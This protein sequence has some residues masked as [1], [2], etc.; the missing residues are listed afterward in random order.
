MAATDPLLL[1]PDAV[2]V[3]VADLPEEVRGRFEHAEGDFALTHPRLRAP[4]RILDAP[5]AE[6]LEQFRT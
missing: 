1:L 3:P 4:S 5:S 2:L 6:L